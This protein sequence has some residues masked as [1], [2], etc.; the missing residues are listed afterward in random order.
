[1]DTNATV[2]L[3]ESFVAARKATSAFVAE[4]EATL[5]GDG[6]E[7]PSP[8]AVAQQIR[9]A[10]ADENAD[11]SKV[12]AI[13]GG[14]PAIA[15]RLLKVANCAL[16]HNSPQ[17]VRDLH[18]AVVRLGLKTV[19][20]LTLSIAAQQV[21]L[22][23]ST[24]RIMPQVTDV[25]RHSL[26]VAT[27]AHLLTTHAPE[28]PED[29]AF[30]AGLL[31]EIGHLYILLRARDR[32]ELIEQPEAFRSIAGEWQ[33]RI[34][35]AIMRAWEFP[36]SLTEAV[37]EHQ[38][39]ALAC[40]APV[41]LTEVVGVANNLAETLD[42]TGDRNAAELEPA[43]LPDFGA[44]NMDSE[45]LHWILAVSATDARQMEAAMAG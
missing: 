21:F 12:A 11:V 37:A 28:V 36:D 20:N 14:D 6:V 35:A 32:A 23:Y 9:Q 26:R 43:D 31:H 44:L 13:I 45:T 19:R 33:S 3:D 16:F 17:P 29:E 24:G 1:M 30:L 34:G 4:L 27:L 2:V 38:H 42:E 5:N 10:V 39:C 8:P 25:W 22:G 41:T 18:T 40:T 15:A 7:L